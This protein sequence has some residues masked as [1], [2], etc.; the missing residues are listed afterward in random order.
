MVV[1]EQTEESFNF[2]VNALGLAVSFRV[3]GCG[4]VGADVQQT[5]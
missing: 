1:N 3:M 5:V 4:Q 2:L